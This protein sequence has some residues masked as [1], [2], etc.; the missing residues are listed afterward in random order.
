[1]KS[2]HTK[3]E[4]IEAVFFNQFESEKYMTDNI[5]KNSNKCLDGKKIVLDPW[6]NRLHHHRDHHHHRRHFGGCLVDFR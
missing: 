3:K 4:P 5:G 6:N 2:F 1:V